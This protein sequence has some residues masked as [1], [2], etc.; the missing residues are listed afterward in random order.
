MSSSSASI[1]AATASGE[2]PS[3]ASSSLSTPPLTRLDAMRCHRF[4]SS[5]V[6]RSTFGSTSRN[7][8]S[9]AR[10]RTRIDSEPVTRASTARRILPYAARLQEP[11]WASQYHAPP[12]LGAARESEGR[13]PTP[14]PHGSPPSKPESQSRGSAPKPGRILAP[15]FP[16]SPSFAPANP[17]SQER[18]GRNHHHEQRDDQ[19]R[20]PYIVS[21]AFAPH[22]Q[23]NAP[24]H[25]KAG[26]DHQAPS[27]KALA[28]RQQPPSLIPPPLQSAPNLAHTHHPA[29]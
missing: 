18:R 28:P 27:N 20:N 29:S 3:F 10:R 24:K 4:R 9:A 17:R 1:E 25:K 13:C 6:D 11:A 5:S 26:R 19:Q 16:S 12:R 8:F 23:G 2:S 14:Q 15:Q 22:E 21:S 7:F